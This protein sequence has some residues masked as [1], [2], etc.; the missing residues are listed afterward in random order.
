MATSLIFDHYNQIDMSSFECLYLLSNP[1][2]QI[3]EVKRINLPDT[4]SVEQKFLWLKIDTKTLD[5]SALNF[6]SMDSAGAVQERYF[7]QGYLKFNE[8]TGTFIEK[9]NSAQH[10][11]QRLEPQHLEQRVQ[12]AITAFLSF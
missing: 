8:Q 9:Y 3:I 7:Q 12:Q 1:Y 11:L 10:P 5:V 2:L 6:S 4:A